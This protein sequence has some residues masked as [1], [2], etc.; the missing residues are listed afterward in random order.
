MVTW[1]AI[2]EEDVH[3]ILRGYHVMYRVTAEED[4]E[5]TSMTTSPTEPTFTMTGLKKHTFYTIKVAG[6]TIKGRGPY[7]EISLST[8]EDGKPQILKGLIK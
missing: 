1:D 3:G 7:A 8:D 2:P 6:Y 5:Y 4:A